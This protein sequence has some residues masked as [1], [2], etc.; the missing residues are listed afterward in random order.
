M[1]SSHNLFL[2][3]PC[4]S[5]LVAWPSPEP[6]WLARTPCATK[7]ELCQEWAWYWSLYGLLN[8]QWCLPFLLLT[9]SKTSSGSRQLEHPIIAFPVFMLVVPEA[10]NMTGSVSQ[11]PTVFSNT[12]QLTVFLRSTNLSFFRVAGWVYFQSYIE[13]ICW[14]N[15]L[16]N[17]TAC[18]SHVANMLQSTDKYTSGHRL[19]FIKKYQSLITSF[20]L[21]FLVKWINNFGSVEE[22]S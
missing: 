20:N 3:S 10:E 1:T 18:C 6:Q 15:Y 9:I 19:I 21:F 13:T 17:M 4:N 11:N 2:H 7:F 5:F 22:L 16:A 14:Y 8:T 12:S